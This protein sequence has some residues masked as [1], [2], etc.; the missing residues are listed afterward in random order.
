MSAIYD[1]IAEK[2]TQIGEPRPAEDLTREFVYR[3]LAAALGGELSQEAVQQ[4]RVTHGDQ[5]P[6]GRAL[7]ALADAAAQVTAD[8]VRDEYR[9][10][11]YDLGG[12]ELLPYASRY[13]AGALHARPLADLRLAL[14]RLGFSR[15]GPGNEPEDHLA[16]LCEVMAVLAA[17]S[18]IAVQKRFFVDHLAPW[19]EKFFTD[20]AAAPGARFYAK[21]A[22]L[23]CVFTKIER[24]AF[25][26]VRGST[27]ER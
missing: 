22:A 14:L 1:E 10:L 8:Q 17:D 19:A 5:T 21:V 24:Q 11:F 26:L 18:G 2:P 9:R 25:D 12:A 23:G 13:V 27:E 7:A 15:A 16:F 4:L 20:L 6:F 3:L